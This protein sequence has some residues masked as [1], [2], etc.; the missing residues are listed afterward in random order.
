MKAP[1]IKAF[2][3]MVGKN[4]PTLLTMSSIVG[5]I[6]T[7][8]MTGYATPKA[9][10]LIDEEKWRLEREWR[11]NEEATEDRVIVLTKWETFK[12]AWTAY[13]PP[14]IMGSATIASI[15]G[16]NAINTKRNAALASAYFLS[17]TALKEYQAKIIEKIGEKKAKLLKDEIAQDRVNK[18]KKNDK[19]IIITGNGNT[20]CLDCTTGR[21]F[22]SSVDKIRRAEIEINNILLD[23]MTMSLNEIYD[24]LGLDHVSVG[25]EIGWDRNKDGKLEFDISACLSDDDEPCITVNFNARA[26]YRYN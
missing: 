25:S 16:N 2:K 5:V 3:L 15:I 17:E 12:A 21:Y 26:N 22:R 9:M 19:S 20:L 4:S 13:I 11:D 1:N 14:V 24:C 6:L 10:S 23:D 18:T 7:G 8:V